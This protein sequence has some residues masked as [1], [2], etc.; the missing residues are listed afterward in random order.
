ME[1]FVEPR[2]YPLIFRLICLC[3]FRIHEQK[4]TYNSPGK[5]LLLAFILFIHES[6]SMLEDKWFKSNACSVLGSRY[7]S[8]LMCC[9]AHVKNLV[10]EKLLHFTCQV[11]TCQGKLVVHTDQRTIDKE[12]LSKKN[13]SSV[14]GLYWLEALPIVRDNRPPRWGLDVYDENI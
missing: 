8:L 14:R 3:V 12:N 1:L 2:T 4:K 10:K 6:S 9:T 5:K 13:C 11:K 7:K